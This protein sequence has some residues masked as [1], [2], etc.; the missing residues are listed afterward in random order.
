MTLILIEHPSLFVKLTH[1]A[2][3]K[4]LAS[5]CLIIPLCLIAVAEQ[6]MSSQRLATSGYFIVLSCHF[7]NITSAGLWPLSQTQ[8]NLIIISTE[9]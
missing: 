5:A 8:I 6:L 1:T 2:S 7:E 3:N 9:I 4:G